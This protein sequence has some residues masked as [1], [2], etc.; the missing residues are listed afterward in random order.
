MTETPRAVEERWI[1][2]ALIFLTLLVYAQVC[3]HDFINLDDQTY[4]IENPHVRNGLTLD[5]IRWAF[6]ESYASNWHPLT[7][8][9]HMLDCELFGL[10]PG[11]H[12]LVN[13]L[14]HLANTVLLF[15]V[16]ARMTRDLWPS[17]LVAALFALHPL[18]VESVAWVAERKD[19]L[20]TFFWMLTMWAYVR[21]VER[22]VV[23]RYLLALIF[24][25]LGLMSK[26]MLV[27]LPL[28]L[29]L[30]DV[31]P[32]HRVGVLQSGRGLP[33]ARLLVE[34]IP[35]FLC[36]LGSSLLTLWAQHRGGAVVPV[37]LVPIAMR[38]E[39]ALTSYA[40]YIGK[41]VW[42]SDLAVYYPQSNPW[43][44]WQVAVA[45]LVFAVISSLVIRE[46]RRRP[47]LAVGWF[48]YVGTLVPV[49][50]IVQVGGQAGAD[51]YTYVPLIGLFVMVAWGLHN[52]R[53]PDTVIKT[54]ARAV[55][56]SCMICTW[57]QLQHWR[58]SVALFQHTLR[59]TQN[60]SLAHFNLGCAL[61]AQGRE[62]EA[63]TQLLEALQIEPTYAKAQYNLEAILIVRTAVAE[64]V[65]G[66]REAAHLRSMLASVHNQLGI[67]F[68]QQG[69]PYKAISHFADA[70][71]LEPGNAMA[72][73]NLGLALLAANRR[74]DAIRE[75]REALQLQPDFTEAHNNLE[76]A[77]KQKGTGSD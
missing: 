46:S 61:Y 3:T 6:T 35:F 11:L 77:L 64:A 63:I 48:W 8:L 28:T 16:L 20:S 22:P 44:T 58:D 36:S 49:I 29:L 57:L 30:L 25:V 33:V 23:S 50:G 42:P 69:R 66:P 65:R 27:T 19:V 26:P 70:V 37:S 32:L 76:A 53:I 34:K 55:V 18:H 15:V 14:F 39:Y 40:R 71:T 59:V 5:G 4:I 75:F 67:I 52:L 17:A 21:Y 72:H 56:V 74:I 12:H 41:M 60:N 45:G 10:N 13:L 62:D 31:W 68:A 7:W 43:P 2:L 24:F 38:M 54:A 9:S 51:R 73:F 47:Y 1:S